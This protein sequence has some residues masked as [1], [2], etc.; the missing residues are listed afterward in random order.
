MERMVKAIEENFPFDQ[1]KFVGEDSH[2]W[3]FEGLYS[4]SNNKCEI[5]VEKSDNYLWHKREDGEDW[6]ECDYLED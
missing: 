4:K 6:F 5:K 2:A 3:Y 1:V